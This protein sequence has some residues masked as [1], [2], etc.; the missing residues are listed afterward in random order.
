[1]IPDVEYSMIKK[2]PRDMSIQQEKR[3]QM[4]MRKFQSLLEDYLITHHIHDKSVK[5][6]INLVPLINIRHQQGH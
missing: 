1:M 4:N 5:S 2:T 6:A 3:E